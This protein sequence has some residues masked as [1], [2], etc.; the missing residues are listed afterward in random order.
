MGH[1][2]RDY[3]PADET[4]WL[5]CRVLSF[6]G[7]AYFDNVLRTKPA[8]PEPGLELVAVGEEGAVVGLLDV[9]VEGDAATIDN[10]AV[11]PDHQAR[12]I[13]AALLAEARARLRAL[14]VTTLDAWTR[15]DPGTLSWYRA[16]GFAESDHYL[17][18]FANHYTDPAETDRA[19]TEPHPDLRPV[20]LFLHADLRHEPAMR[21]QF[22]RVHVCRRFSAAL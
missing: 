2:V 6:L 5:R 8:I 16:M 9:T 1:A 19:I 7:T 4:S 13:G 15:D 10:V 11:H 3:A 12:G 21:E 22:A 14:G 18:V 17:H 20:A